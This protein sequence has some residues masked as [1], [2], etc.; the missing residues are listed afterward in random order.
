MK[1]S[2]VIPVYGRH[3]IDFKKCWES[4]LKYTD[5]SNIEIII[6]ANGCYD[7]MKDYLDSI[8]KN[9]N[10]KYFWF[11]QALG[12]TLAINKGIEK[13]TGDIIIVLNQD[14]EILGDEW[15]NYLI[16]PFEDSKVGITGP[17][18]GA[19]EILNKDDGKYLNNKE[20]IVF[21]C[22]AIR[23]EVINSIG[24]LDLSFN[25]GSFEDID[26]GIKAEDAGWKLVQVP[27]EGEYNNFPIFHVDSHNE[28]L[29][30]AVYNRNMKII[31]DRY[32]NRNLMEKK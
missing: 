2:I 13:T 16:K 26:Y 19:V 27:N 29:S 3:L 18:K 25:P 32:N 8:I 7:S 6:I 15:L 30:N 4:I 10:H 24:L 31:F 21:F 11:E 20:F 12:A 28:W 17:K 5:T 22:V 1:I 14:V 23:R 9:P